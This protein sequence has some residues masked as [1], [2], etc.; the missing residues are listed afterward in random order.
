MNSQD[1]AAYQSGVPSPSP[2]LPEISLVVPV[3]NE[4]DVIT[5]FLQRVT[6]I[7]ESIDP[8]YEIIFV[9]DGSS[10][11][12]LNVLREVNLTDHRVKTVDLA[13]NFG[14]EIA[15]SA[16]IDAAIGRAVIPMDVDL[17]DPPELIPQMVALWR[18]GWDM[19]LAKRAD[20]STD[21]FMKRTTSALFY[22]LIASMSDTRIPENVGD[23]RLLDRRV[24]D[25]LKL[26]PERTRFMK[27]IFAWLGFRQTTVEYVRERRA[28][29]TTK[30]RPIGLWKLAVE[31]IV[32]FSTFPLKLWS[33]VGAS[34]AALA[35]LYCVTVVVRALIWGDPV[36]GYPSLVAITLFLNGIVLMGLGVIGEYLSRIFIEVKQRPLYLVREYVGA[37]QTPLHPLRSETQLT[38]ADA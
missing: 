8:H 20:R 35:F 3:L 19:V 38:A 12:T 34:C 10:D 30:W 13:R 32:S 37:A 1:Q 33:Y 16:G 17:Q 24:V 21:S 5:L 29:G 7:L 2:A 22:K 31:G 15:L 14:K 18:Q 4:Q 11:Q 27:G 26:L 36:A 6:P 23:F 9:N 25:A 28:A